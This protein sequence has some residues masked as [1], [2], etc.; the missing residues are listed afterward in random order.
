MEWVG[1]ILGILGSIL[2]AANTEFTKYAWLVFLGSNI[3]WIIYGS[4][5]KLWALVAMQ[6]GYLIIDGIGAYRWF[7]L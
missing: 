4:K 5:R 3:I 1:T 2:F 6:V 7:I